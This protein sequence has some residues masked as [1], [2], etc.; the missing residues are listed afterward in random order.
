[1][2]DKATLAYSI[3]RQDVGL[4]YKKPK[5]VIPIGSSNYSKLP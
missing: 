4:T 2:I 3:P 5:D 1:L